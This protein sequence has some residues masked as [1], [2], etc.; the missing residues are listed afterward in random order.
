MLDSVCVQFGCGL[1][2]PIQWLNFDS[3]PTLQLQRLPLLG[4]VAPAGPYGRFPKNV[5]YGDIVRGLP[6]PN[7]S[8][9]L[10]YCSHVLEHLALSDLRTAL[11]N[12]RRILR[13]GGTFRL[14]LPDLEFLVSEYLADSSSEAAVRFMESTMLGYESR[15]RG[16]RAMLRHWLGN[17]RHLWMWDF[18]GLAMELQIAGFD[19]IRRA[20][21]NDS[22]VAAFCQVETADRWTNCLGI[23]CF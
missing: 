9:E 2:A 23:E 7:D 13:I 10:L 19:S 17:S 1:H 4:R 6:V 8:V 5:H 12:C 20:T 3:S 16:V 15:P 18:K 21:Y 11:R 22:A 14:V